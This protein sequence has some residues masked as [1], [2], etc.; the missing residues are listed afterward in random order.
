MDRYRD[1]S[2]VDGGNGVLCDRCRDVFLCNTDLVQF[3]KLADTMQRLSKN[4]DKLGMILRLP[5]A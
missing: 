5:I 1:Q 3:P 2:R 4:I